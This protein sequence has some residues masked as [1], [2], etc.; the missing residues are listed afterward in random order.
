MEYLVTGK[1][2]QAYDIYTIEHIGI[3]AMVLMERAALETVRCIREVLLRSDMP[4]ERGRVLCVCGRGNNGGDG[5]CVARLLADLGIDVDTVLIGNAA[6]TSKETKVQ[7]SILEKYGIYPS[8]EI[9]DNAYDVIVDALFGT[10]LSRE[11]TGAYKKAI[12]SINARNAYRI[13]IDIPSGIDADT[14][15]VLGTAVKADETVTLAFRK[16]G[17]YLYPGCLYAGK[18]RLADIGITQK[19][20]CGRQPGMYTRLGGVKDVFPVRKPDGNKGTFGKLLL[21]AGSENMAG[22]A[23]LAGY[24]A[25]KAGVGMVK[26]VIPEKIREIVQKKLPEALIQTYESPKRLSPEEEKE[27]LDNLEWAQ[28]AAIGP[29]LSVCETARQFVR[30]V[31]L[32]KSKPL[33][34]DADALNILAMDTE[35]QKQLKQRCREAG[36]NVILTPHMGE[37]A[38]LLGVPTEEV[39]ADEAGSVRE[40]AKRT[41][42]IV[43]GK[44]ARTYVCETDGGMF[45]NTAGNSKMATAGSGDVLTGI[46]AAMLAQGMPPRMAAENGVFLHACAGDAAAGQAGTTGLLASEIAKGLKLL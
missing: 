16:R 45:L 43:V 15:D 14:G 32:Q 1:E 25:Y 24:S 34:M 20:F 8:D 22:A 42:C 38:R 40:T 10:G 7:L 28:T 23:L 11:V 31:V 4:R 39:S 19:S 18:I 44:S 17:L 41:G 33:V 29:G 21:V 6:K 35:I 26:L 27:F 46:I 12:E 5:L 3:P 9:L 37:L 2:M 36:S 13:S 30:L